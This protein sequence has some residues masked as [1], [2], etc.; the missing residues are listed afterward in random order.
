MREGGLLPT[1]LVLGTREGWVR[2]AAPKSTSD[3]TPKFSKPK[4]A[5]LKV[6][7]MNN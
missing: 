6:W 1:M 5:M 4:M 2:V 7:L 3:P